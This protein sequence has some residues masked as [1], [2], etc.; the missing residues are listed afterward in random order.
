MLSNVLSI[1]SLFSL[2]ERTCILC[3]LVCLAFGNDGLKVGLIGLGWR[4]RFGIAW[5]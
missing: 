1:F 5:Y 4:F 2:Y 3:F